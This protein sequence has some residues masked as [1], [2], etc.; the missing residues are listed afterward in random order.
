MAGVDRIVIKRVV[1]GVVGDGLFEFLMSCDGGLCD[2][3][4]GVGI[5]KK[6]EMVAFDNGDFAAVLRMTELNEP[7]HVGNC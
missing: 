7:G 3:I 5:A 2:A 1:G 6:E 4:D